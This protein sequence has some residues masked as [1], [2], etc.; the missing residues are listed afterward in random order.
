MVGH[1]PPKKNQAPSSA[2]ERADSVRPTEEPPASR[3]F[4]GLMTEVSGFA[5]SAAG[6]QA[7]NQ[8]ERDSEQLLP[9]AAGIINGLA[10]V[11][12]KQ[13][14]QTETRRGGVFK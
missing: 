2:N 1:P 3:Q 9:R 4:S 13:A 6:K 12:R 10:E 11:G 5:P 8:L 14:S 7:G